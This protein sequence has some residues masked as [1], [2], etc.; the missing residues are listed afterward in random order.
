MSARHGVRKL[1]RWATAPHVRVVVELKPVD[2]LGACPVTGR[3][4]DGA[5]GSR[6]RPSLP[7]Q[8]ATAQKG[9]APSASVATAILAGR[10]S[11]ALRPTPTPTRASSSPAAT[12][13]LG[14]AA[15]R[16][17]HAAGEA[18]RSWRP[19]GQLQ[20]RRPERSRGARGLRSSRAR[21]P[22]KQGGRQLAQSGR[23]RSKNACPST[24]AR[25]TAKGRAATK[26][27]EP[28]EIAATRAIPCHEES[29]L[30]YFTRLHPFH[31]P[32]FVHAPRPGR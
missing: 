2:H 12:H 9:P 4:R 25:S 16:I 29:S 5:V 24:V 21:A 26:P 3:S 31:P 27:R 6:A 11:I 18:R 28:G 22:S 13:T 15:A 23:W 10:G 30:K 17:R 19:E 8:A 20:W 32:P 1:P 7:G 14:A